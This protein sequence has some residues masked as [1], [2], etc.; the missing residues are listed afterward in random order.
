MRLRKFAKLILAT[1]YGIQ[2]VLSAYPA[3]NRVVIAN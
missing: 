1:P 3:L 2:E